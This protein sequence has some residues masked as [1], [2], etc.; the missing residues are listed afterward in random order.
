VVLKTGPFRTLAVRLG[1]VKLV[2]GYRVRAC[3]RSLREGARHLT[4]VNSTAVTIGA[5][6]PLALKYR[7]RVKTRF[8]F[9]LSATAG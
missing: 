9:R 1:F 3:R 7:L 5:E 4:S 2:Y 6:M 8:D